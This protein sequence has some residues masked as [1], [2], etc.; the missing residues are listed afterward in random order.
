MRDALLWNDTRSAAA[1]ADLAAEMAAGSR[2]WADAVG[3]LPLASFTITKLRWLAEHEP[4]NAARAAAV[5]LPHDWLTWKVLGAQGIEALTTDRGDASGTGYWSP[6]SETY[7][8]D[9]L[10]MAFGRDLAVPAVLAPDVAAGTG[11]GSLAV[12]VGTGD[13]AAAAIGV[14][15]RTG[16]LL[17]S[18]G[19]SGVVAAV[20]P[21]PTRD[22]SGIVAGFADATGA[23]LPLACTL[24][25]SLVLEAAARMLGVSLDG[26]SELALSA[27]PGA[28][29]LTL[30]PYLAGERTP[31]LPDATGSLVGLTN[32][33]TTPANLARAAVEGLLCGLADGVDA[34][35]AN[36]VEVRR[37]V[38][39]GGGARS[40]ALRRIAPSIFGLPV[41]VPP[42]G[43][44]VADG[45][46]RQALW[47]LDHLQGRRPDVNAVAPVSGQQ[48]YEADPVGWVRE[49]YRA[50]ATGSPAGTVTPGLGTSSA[51]ARGPGT[52]R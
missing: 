46:A 44:H 33:N 43:E 6:L 23:Y 51:V 37:A 48:R 8:P 47:A 28:G 13:N 10:R 30:V 14:G 35:R 22:P 19:T 41:D 52:R 34:L 9:L 15:A 39:V 17:V 38:L 40:E 45:A 27:R 11:P 7:R 4:D 29:G 42:E 16:D 26:L 50:A 25:A 1:A 21:R 3:S 12:G 24:N 31:N 32:D 2:G 18:V 5:C 36:G 49:Q 20:H